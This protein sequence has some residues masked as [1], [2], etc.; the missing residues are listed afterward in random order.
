M[1]LSSQ[2]STLL[3]SAPSPKLIQQKRGSEI[4][5][6]S[7][8]TTA[9]ALL[10]VK[11]TVSSLAADERAA[12]LTVQYRDERFN[13]LAGPYPG[14]FHSDTAGQYR[15]LP[16]PT[17]A[18]GLHNFS[19]V[20]DVPDGAVYAKFSLRRWNS[21]VRLRS[22]KIEIDQVLW[23]DYLKSIDASRM[24]AA[25]LRQVINQAVRR[26]DLKTSRS[27]CAHLYRREKIESDG[28]RLQ[29]LN[30]LWTELDSRWLP[31]VKLALRPQSSREGILHLLKVIYPQESSGGAVRNWDVVRCQAKLGLKPVVSLSISAE[32]PGTLAADDIRRDGMSEEVR[33]GVLISCPQFSGFHRSQ[34]PP[35]V[36]LEA[37]ANFAA[38]T[39]LK[40]GCDI[41]HATSG[42][43]GFDNALKGMALAKRF[44]LPWVYEVRSFHEHTWGPPTSEILSA[45]L[46]QMRMEQEKRCMLE[47]DVVITISEAMVEHLV[48]RG[49]Q[50]EKVR[51]VPNA[52]SEDFLSPADSAGA[53]KLKEQFGLSDRV[54][55]GYVSNMSARE[56]HSVL[57]KAFA[58]VA[59]QNPKLVC[60]LVG[61]GREYTKLKLLGEQLGVSDRLIMPGEL[62]HSIIK[63]VYSLIDI[64]VVPRVADFAADYVTPMKP[65]EALAMGC[66][67][68]MS[69]RPVAGEVVGKEERGLLFKTSDDGDLAR[70]ITQVLENDAAALSR[71]S[72]GRSWI[73]KERTWERNALIYSSIYSELREKRE[74]NA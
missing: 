47:A 3:K 41:V 6:V 55:V 66:R 63:D 38:D 67:L 25:S 60:L 61:N 37:E 43:K 40:Y 71:A 74:F 13:L 49:I 17:S 12:I 1:R 59:A 72:A 31:R 42:F 50:R 19:E 44:D 29:V 62:D 51:L 69:D 33:E 45:P 8:E 46:T 57:L 28:Y 30:G 70:K 32:K 22:K 58:R 11:C 16:I 35:D 14:F 20:I 64:F 21:D 26:G 18:K 39:L 24:G 53:A 23:D 73:K 10:L 52:V 4:A 48:A 54:V 36:L 9:G 5:S 68:I 65:F 34:I 56:G 27:I 7:I 15:Y 2:R